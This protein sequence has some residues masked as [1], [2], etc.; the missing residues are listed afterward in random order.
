MTSAEL[1]KFV[2]FLIKKGNI[3]WAPQKR[4]NIVNYAMIENRDNFQ[5]VEEAPFYSFKKYLVPPEEILFKYKEGELAEV[6]EAKKQIIFGVNQIDLR[7]LVLLNHVFEKDPWYQERM[8]KTLIIGQSLIPREAEQNIFHYK[9]EEDVLEHLQ[10]DIFIE[11]QKGI[12]NTKYFLYTGSEDGQRILDEFSAQGG[13]SSGDYE[14]IQFSGPIKEEGLD[15]VMVKY[16][17]AIKNKYK[18]EV[19]ERDLGERCIECG[20]C[21]TVCPTCFCFDIKDQTELKGNEGTRAR[22]QSSCFFSDFSEISG[23][24]E[25][26]NNTAERIYFWY[27]HKFVKIPD[28]FSIPG[29]VGCGRCAKVCPVNINIFKVLSELTKKNEESI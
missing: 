2:D 22:V 28:E 1:R 27:Y 15:L 10:F 12:F 25:F 23:K 26:L 16:R 17:D 11:I 18:K 3:V 20:K 8:K 21:T 13:S 7:A 19:W 9:Y 14:H 24:Y 29:C 4:N 5:L 6:N